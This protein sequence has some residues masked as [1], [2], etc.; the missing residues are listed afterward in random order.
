VA[1]AALWQL[2]D[3][4]RISA[5]LADRTVRLLLAWFVAAFALANHDLLISPRQPIHFTHGYVWIP[6]FLIAAPT[7][8]DITKRLLALRGPGLAV[9]TVLC[10]L[11]LLDNA[12]WFGGAGIDLADNGKSEDFFPNPI[13]IDHRAQDVLERLSGEEFADGLVVS[14]ERPL[15]YQTIVQSPLRA[16]YSHEWNTPHSEQRLAELDALFHLGQD[17][18]DWRR[19]KM[20]AVV[21][22][23][24]DP[25]AS[26]ML[27]ALGYRLAY[28]NAGYDILLRLPGSAPH[29]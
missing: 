13:Y 1:F 5:A 17:I 12:V 14:N 10:G 25:A 24:K 18:D 8:V 3:R 29:Q 15:S 23:Q 21:Q 27:M 11:M 7:L 20:I 9:L 19:R 4:S 16:W 2:R 26:G 28:Q 22:R 6:L